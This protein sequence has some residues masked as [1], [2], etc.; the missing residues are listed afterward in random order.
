MVCPDRWLLLLLLLLLLA[1]QPECWTRSDRGPRCHMRAVPAR[2]QAA[3]QQVAGAVTACECNVTDAGPARVTAMTVV[4]PVPPAQT[5]TSAQLVGQLF[6][7]AGQHLQRQ[8]DDLQQ[9]RECRKKAAFKGLQVA[10]HQASWGKVLRRTRQCATRNSKAYLAR[11]RL[12]A[13]V[14]TQRSSI[15]TCA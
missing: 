14:I 8:S 6:E 15:A 13:M 4:D 5:P 12:T 7:D 11:S 9:H 3:L 1:L 2:N 10:K